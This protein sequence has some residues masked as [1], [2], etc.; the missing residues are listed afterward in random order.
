MRKKKLLNVGCDLRYAGPPMFRGKGGG[1]VVVVF[2]L[3]LW[4]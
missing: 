1:G 3:P 4:V 2:W